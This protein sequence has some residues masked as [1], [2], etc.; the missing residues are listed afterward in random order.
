MSEKQNK[1]NLKNLSLKELSDFFVSVGEKPFRAKQI[2]QWLYCNRVEDFD[3]MRNISKLTKGKL[4]AVADI[5]KLPVIAKQKSKDGSAVKLAI[6][7]SKVELNGRSLGYENKSEAVECV[8]LSDGKRN[9]ACLSSQVGCKYGCVYCSTALMG[10][11]RNLNQV[12]II[13]QLIA[14]QDNSS[15]KRISN[16]VF[17][18]MGEPLDNLGNVL[19][20][21]EIIQSNLGFSIGG[22]KITI[23]TCGLVPKIYELADLKTNLGLA[24]SL[25]ASNN[26]LRDKLMPVN[27]KYP[28]E[29]LLDAAGYY[30]EK[31]GRRV[32]FE[33]V[34]IDGINDSMQN[35]K[36]LRLL[37]SRFPCKLNFITFYPKPGSEF[38]S[39]S[40]TKIRMI[41]A[42]FETSPFTV[43]L[44]KPMGADISAACG[45]LYRE[46]VK[47]QQV[48]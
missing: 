18:G 36:E 8:M 3:E 19:R 42:F 11:H 39:P 33:Y 27:K 28:L 35:M 12:E 23:S 32:T 13:E 7:L 6:G 30:F 45:Q 41:V 26:S 48:L 14:L 16:V 4:E 1:I 22:R 46:L 15:G 21:V 25:N 43:T 10:F 20:S 5:S 34:L 2:M 29:K 31:T 40:M 37:L 47:K 24:I 38:K 17:M 9:T 44:R